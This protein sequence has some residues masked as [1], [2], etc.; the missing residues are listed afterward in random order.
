[1]SEF[2]WRRI[3]QAWLDHNIMCVRG[4]DLTIPDFIA[5]SERFGA[6][7]AASIQIDTAS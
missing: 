4:Q 3:Y 7:D 5:Y 1:M 6:G 2:E